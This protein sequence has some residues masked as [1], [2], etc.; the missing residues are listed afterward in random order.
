MM[1]PSVKLKKRQVEYNC[2]FDWNNF[3]KD[4]LSFKAEQITHFKLKKLIKDHMF[5]KY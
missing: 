3:K 2:I 1:F 5:K 4:F